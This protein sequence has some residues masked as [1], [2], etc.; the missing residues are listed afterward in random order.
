MQGSVGR[1][2]ST[3]PINTVELPASKELPIDNLTTADSEHPL[4]AKQGKALKDSADS[5]ASA[6]SSAD[7]TLQS[8]INSEASSRS[9]ADGVLQGQIDNLHKHIFG[10]LPTVTE[11]LSSPADLAHTPITGSVRVYFNGEI[12]L[13]VTVVG[14][15][16]T[17]QA[18]LLADDVVLV[19][20]LYV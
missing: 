8:N 18:P 15:T 1:I 7:G 2:G 17:F 6:R 14:K 13:S 19:D 9:T 11:G 3:N 4:S 16:I 12:D 20:Y 5:E 10:E